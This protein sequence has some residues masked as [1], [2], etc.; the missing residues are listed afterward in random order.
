MK[1]SI[2]Y[3]RILR[4]RII[5]LNKSNT[6]FSIDINSPSKHLKGVLVI[7]TQERSATKFARDTEE[8]YN[9]KITK[10]KATVEGVPNELYAQNMEYRHQYDEIIKHFSEGW[11][12]EARAIQKDLQLHNINIAS[13]YTDKYGLWLDF[14]T[15]HDNRLHG[16]GR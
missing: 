10:V 16:S 14:R 11:L 1:S 15:I 13:Y 7:F 12:K 9:P 5:P 3:D 2:L 6:S 8:F 4:A